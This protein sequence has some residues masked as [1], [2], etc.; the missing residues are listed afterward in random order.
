M[1]V[2]GLRRNGPQWNGVLYYS[3][4]I[5]LF[6]H[7]AVAVSELSLRGTGTG[8]HY[9]QKHGLINGI[10]VGVVQAFVWIVSWILQAETVLALNLPFRPLLGHPED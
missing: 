5:Q 8:T 2:W 10:R 4:P 7:I 1:R 6:M 3:G 9:L